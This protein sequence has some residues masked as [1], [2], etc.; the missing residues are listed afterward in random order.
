MDQATHQ[1]NHP[2]LGLLEVSSIARGIVVGDGM[3]K[4]APVEALYA[5]TTH[6]GKFLLLVQGAVAHVQEALD[7]GR[8]LAADALL[9]QLFLPDIHPSLSAALRGRLEASRGDAL[10]IIETRTVASLLGAVDRALK[11]AQVSLT[12]LRLAD[13][14]GGK[15][16]CLLSGELADVEEAMDL[17]CAGLEGFGP[18]DPS[19]LIER[20]IIPRLHEEMRQNLEQKA[21]LRHWL[22]PSG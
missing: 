18:N 6:P 12:E 2:A 10:G 14:L 16:Y 7:A 8:E 21:E 17:A 11:G 1:A 15:G 9:D 3:V 19:L 20:A 5:G 13:N 4:E 22:R